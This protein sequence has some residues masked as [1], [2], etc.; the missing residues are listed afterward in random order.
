MALYEI[1]YSLTIKEY[2]DYHN[3]CGFVACASPG[4]ANVTMPRDAKIR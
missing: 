4:D 2:K 1:Q 3:I